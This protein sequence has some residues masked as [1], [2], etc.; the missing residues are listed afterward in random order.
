MDCVKESLNSAYGS[1]KVSI[2]DAGVRWMVH[3]SQLDPRYGGIDNL[4]TYD[5]YKY[6]YE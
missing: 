3:H 6:H 4:L 5:L 2:A 1:D